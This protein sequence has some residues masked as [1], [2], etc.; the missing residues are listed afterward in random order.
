MQ[1]N[2]RVGVRRGR[3]RDQRPRHTVQRR[4]FGRDERT[5]LI[6]LGFPDRADVFGLGRAA[7]V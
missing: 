1:I 7:A 6:A 4:N 3:R 2:D 5:A